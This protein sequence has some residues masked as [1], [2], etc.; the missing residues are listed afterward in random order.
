MSGGNKLFGE[1]GRTAVNGGG[2]EQSHQ[3]P[4]RPSSGRPSAS[5]SD[6][7]KHLRPHS[8]REPP[9]SSRAECQYPSPSH[10]LPRS[11]SLRNIPEITPSSNGHRVRVASPDDYD[12]DMSSWSMEK[13][14][15]EFHR[16]ARLF[17]DHLSGLFPGVPFGAMPPSRIVEHRPGGSVHTIMMS[18]PDMM[19]GITAAYAYEDQMKERRRGG[20]GYR[21]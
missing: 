21:R 2:R 3:N 12:G 5:A 17:P 19:R 15:R 20:G 14:D 1:H 9:H 13:L 7:D 11:N 6:K 16:V 18:R 4:Y 10:K 8:N